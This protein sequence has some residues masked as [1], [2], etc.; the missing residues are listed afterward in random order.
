M[1]TA[2]LQLEGVYVAM[3]ALMAAL[4]DSGVLGRDDIDR[5]LGRAEAALM[6]DSRRPAQ[7]SAAN[8]EAICFP[9]R[10]LRIAN[11]AAADDQPLSF[12]ELAA[13][14]AQRKNGREAGAGGA[15]R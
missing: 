1:N 4:R 9:L 8:V 11:E 3:T 12:S 7:L 13:R 15:G 10:Y 14:V 6:A 5:A 2:N